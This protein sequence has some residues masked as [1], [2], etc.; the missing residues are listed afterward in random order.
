MEIEF[1]LAKL[2]VN[3]DKSWRL[4]VCE[5]LRFDIEASWSLVSFERN[6]K[7]LALAFWS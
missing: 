5:F 7:G 1:Y 2:Y 4:T 6:G 3:P